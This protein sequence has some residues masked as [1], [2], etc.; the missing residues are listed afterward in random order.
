MRAEALRC[1]RSHRL[2]TVRDA[3]KICVVTDGVITEEG[4]HQSL[5]QNPEVIPVQQMIEYV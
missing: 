4:T 3:N 5:L 2:S 1:V